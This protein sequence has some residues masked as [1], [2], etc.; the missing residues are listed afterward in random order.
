M[1]T[2]TKRCKT[3]QR[4]LPISEFNQK[5]ANCKS[6]HHAYLKQWRSDH[7]EYAREYMKTYYAQNA[8][9]M[10][11]R[12]R[13]WYRNNRER[14]L[15]TAKEWN[16]RNPDRLK[17][18]AKYHNRKRRTYHLEFTRSWRKQHP[19]GQ[20]IAGHRRRARKRNL[21]DTFTKQDW[22]RA[23]DYFDHRCAVCG[24]PADF[25]RVISPDHWIPLAN[26]N[27]PGTVPENIIPLCNSTKDGEGGCNNSKQAREPIEWL[28]DKF[29]QRKAKRILARIEAYFALVK[30]K[31]D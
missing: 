12:R 17:A 22:H 3:C 9:H 19:E 10:R 21:P 29:G 24:K 27:C 4:E 6:C 1:D 26:P 31:H 18:I 5:Q 20:R 30:P 16:K 14:S 23:L 8:D 25:W 28:I 15:A 11:E 13:E 7:P 2:P